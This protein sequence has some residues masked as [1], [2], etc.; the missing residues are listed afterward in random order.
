MIDKRIALAE[1]MALRDP[2]NIKTVIGFDGF[3]DE[4]IHVVDKREDSEHFTRI[5]KINDLAERIARAGG[6]STNIELFPTTRKLGGNGPIMANALSMHKC[7]QTYIGALGVPVI[8]SVFAEMATKAEVYSLTSSGHT[9]AL[10]FDDGKLLLGKMSSLGDITYDRLVLAVGFDRL[11]KL[12]E[13]ADLFATV[14][15]S[16]IPHMTELWKH[17]LENVVPRLSDKKKKPVFFVDLADP[18]KRKD[19]EIAEALE[20]IAGFRKHYF[21]IL[22][23]NKKEAYGLAGSLGLFSS[24]SLSEDLSLKEVN[25]ALYDFIGIDCVVI[26]PVDRSS[27]VAGGNF[28]E[29]FGPYIKTP[30]LSTGAGDNF[31]AG[32]VL[33]IMLGFSPDEAL[34]M[35]MGTSGF[36]VRKAKSPDYAELTGFLRD[37]AENKI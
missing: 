30:K 12:L 1:K 34:L 11:V 37:W 24:K 20:V 19:E 10:E 7:H 27:T 28:Y 35:G 8:D 18:E 25:Q 13:E 3:I 22:G 31:N 6:L 23:L 4:I 21:V 29:E 2:S 15:W 9:D 5:G 33:G 17:L 36:Y 26:H 14:N 32:F 16:M